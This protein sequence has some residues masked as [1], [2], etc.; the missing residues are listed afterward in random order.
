MH[1]KHDRTNTFNVEIVARVKEG[2]YGVDLKIF[3]FDL[4]LFPRL[5]HGDSRLSLLMT[6]RTL[7]CSVRQTS[8]HHHFPST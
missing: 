4:H 2:K 3:I 6:Y 1:R 8:V 7:I 5:R